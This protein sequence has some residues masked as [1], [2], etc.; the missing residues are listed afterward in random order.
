MLRLM[1]CLCCVILLVAACGR[2]TQEAA[3]EKKIEDATGGKADVDMSDKGMKVSG[4]TEEGK[5]E[6]T[7]GDA[8]K[9][10]DDFPADVFIYKPSKAVM[11]MKV[12]EGFSVTLQT[13]DDKA[14]VLSA[15]K[16]Q[17]AAK[18][19]SEEGS[20]DM[21]DQSMRMYK[22]DQRMATVNLTPSDEGLAI[23]LSVGAN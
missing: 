10:P 2:E 17:M 16:E 15:Y 4:E 23:N 7:G 6:M 12:P 1:L 18:G 3:M 14:K 9:I 8:A 13:K 11:A 20:M 5:Y 22:K 19:W 21:G